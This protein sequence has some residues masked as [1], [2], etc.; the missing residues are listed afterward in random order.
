VAAAGA[1][2]CDHCGGPLRD[3][4]ETD[5]AMQTLCAGCVEAAQEAAREVRAA[6]VAIAHAQDAAARAA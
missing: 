6:A 1:G 2:A 5:Y 4:A 3:D